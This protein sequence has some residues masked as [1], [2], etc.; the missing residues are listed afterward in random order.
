MIAVPVRDEDVV[1]GNGGG[2]D[3]WRALGIVDEEGVYE[4]VFAL[5][6]EM[7]GG[8]AEVSN[9]VCHLMLLFEVFIF[10]FFIIED[11]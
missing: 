10:L 11:F 9:L 6:G 3:I 5:E 4:D 7:K 2:G 1:G 8:M